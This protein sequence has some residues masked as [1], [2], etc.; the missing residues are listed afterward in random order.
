M[1]YRLSLPLL[2]PM[3]R[4]LVQPVNIDHLSLQNRFT[5]LQLNRERIRKRIT[6]PKREAK[7]L[8]IEALFLIK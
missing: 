1:T 3:D 6:L 4:A 5:F 2:R 8:F 7:V